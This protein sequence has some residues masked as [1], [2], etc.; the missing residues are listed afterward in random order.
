[1]EKADRSKSLNDKWFIISIKYILHLLAMFYASY[2]ILQFME[3]D[4]IILG[5]FSKVSIFTWYILYMISR[6]FKFCYVHRL[7]LY[8]IAIVEI[9]TVTDTYIR[10]PISTTNLLNLHIFLIAVLIIGYSIYYINKL[11]HE[12]LQKIL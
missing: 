9:I 5:Y 3:I 2:N 1:M 6:R 7:P 4:F 8:Y 11:K 12:K 10:L